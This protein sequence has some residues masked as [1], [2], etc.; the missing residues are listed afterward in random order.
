MDDST[1]SYGQELDK[2]LDRNGLKEKSNPIEIYHAVRNVPYSSRGDRRPLG[3]LENNEG[4]CSGKHILLRD[5]LRHTGHEAVI[6][7]V[8]GDFAAGIPPLES[9]P[10]A[11]RRMCHDGGVKDFHQYVVWQGPDGECKL[12]ATWPDGLI[13]LGV[14]GN[15]DWNGG[16]DTRLALSPD[17]VLKRVEDIPAYKEQLLASLTKEEE[18]YRLQFLALLTDWV[19]A[20]DCGGVIR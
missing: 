11:L 3:V 8:Q 15:S 20:I 9:M 6:E 7:T 5:L 19:S 17:A 14:P 1:V 4:S 16:R 13:A 18:T 2:F 10:E 12:D